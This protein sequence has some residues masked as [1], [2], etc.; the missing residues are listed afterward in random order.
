M[1]DKRVAS[2]TVVFQA[3]SLNYG[4]G[5][6]NISELKK[7]TRANGHQYT[8]A[9]RQALRYDIVRLAHE[10]F[11]W[12]LE[13]LSASKGTIQFRD[14]VTIRESEEMDLFG[15]MKTRKGDEESSGG[16]STRSAVVRL[17]HAISLEPYKN[18]LEFLS[19]MGF[20][21][22]L[23][24]DPNIANIEQHL[25][26]YSYSVTIDLAKVGV[27][28]SI[29][30]PKEE[31]YRRVSQLLEVLKILNRQ[32]RGRIENLAPLFVIGGLYKV[33]MAL[34]AGTIKLFYGDKGPA[35]DLEPLK[36]VLET[37]FD[38]YKIKE[39]TSYGIVKGIFTNERDIHNLLSGDASGE[40]PTPDSFFEKLKSKI[41]EYYG[42]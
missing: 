30:L 21:K 22:R 42:V 5:F 19:N 25:S 27:D 20:A 16:A 36:S 8:F 32:I 39:D 17:T 24:I 26:F 12:N 29:E 15:Y 6:G 18:D 31:R 14:D 10:I 35:I 1:K 4:E 37:Q 41:K 7:F 23:G 2:F 33:P 40:L 13:T 28:G 3:Q 34:F 11:G 38:G 9:S